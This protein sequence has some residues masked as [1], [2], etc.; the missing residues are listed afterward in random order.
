TVI[1]LANNPLIN[2]SAIAFQIAEQHFNRSLRIAYAVAGKQS[3]A[4]L[5]AFTGTFHDR[6][7]GRVCDLLVEGGELVAQLKQERLALVPLNA[8]QFQVVGVLDSI[9]ITFEIA[10]AGIP[11]LMHLLVEGETLTTFDAVERVSPFADELEVFVG[12]FFS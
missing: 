7:S 11:A 1:C 4:D 3:V 9:T 5:H 6:R 2:P 12:S 8:S 10:S